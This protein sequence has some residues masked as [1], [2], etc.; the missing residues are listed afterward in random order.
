MLATA[1]IAYKG[2]TRAGGWFLAGVLAVLV[3]EAGMLS[4]AARL[5]RFGQF[6]VKASSL[7]HPQ[8][9][10]PKPAEDPEPQ[11]EQD[12]VKALVTLGAGRKL[13][14]AA[15]KKSTGATFPERLR[16]AVNLV[17]N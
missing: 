17:R 6:L 14:A 9:P 13:A 3:L 12:L 15:A 7:Y 10:H 1:V 4:S 5:E 16:S 11:P 2:E 8:R